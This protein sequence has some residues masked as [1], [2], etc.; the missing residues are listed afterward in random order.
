MIKRLHIAASMILIASACDAGGFYYS[1][2]LGYH[3][4]TIDCP[5]TCF[6]NNVLFIGKIGYETN[7]GLDINIKHIS[8]PTITEK[9]WGFNGIFIEKRGDFFK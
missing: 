7:Q 8:A 6:G 5:E 1:V 4:E 9:G 2:G 3:D